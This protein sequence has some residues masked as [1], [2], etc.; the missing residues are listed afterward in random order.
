VP[1]LEAIAKN[2]S[3]YLYVVENHKNIRNDSDLARERS[4]MKTIL[5]SGHLP[6]L[7]TRTTPRFPKAMEPAARD[8]FAGYLKN[9]PDALIYMSL[10]SGADCLFAE[11]ALNQGCSIHLILPCHV[12]DF[13]KISVEPY[14]PEGIYTTTFHK[15]I[16]KASSV[17]ELDWDKMNLPD[18]EACN[19]KILELASKQKGEIL[20]CLFVDSSSEVI[21]GGSQ[22][23]LKS[24]MENG[25][26]VTN[27]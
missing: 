5:F 6:D 27:L 10:A 18:F 15:I 3:G 11:E 25:I 22:D 20:A 12:K 9:H 8:L 2:A 16:D 7:P 19:R 21:K 17:L 1:E 26:P 4:I 24:I 13:L 23:F 14:D